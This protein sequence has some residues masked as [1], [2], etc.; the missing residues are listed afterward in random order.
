MS[1]RTRMYQSQ[2]V[3]QVRQKNDHFTTLNTKSFQ[4]IPQD[5]KKAKIERR[6]TR[7]WSSSA[8]MKNVVACRGASLLTL[9]LLRSGAAGAPSWPG[10]RPGWA[11]SWPGSAGGSPP[12]PAPSA[13]AGRLAAHAALPQSTS[14]PA[15][16]DV[17]DVTGGHAH[18]LAA[19][20]HAKRQSKLEALLVW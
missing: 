10:W 20:N 13:A 17:P 16:G 3:P 15:G 4:K 19:A 8:E 2:T 14:S 9:W 5:L 7:A 1:G 6:E 12:S 11:S 18:T